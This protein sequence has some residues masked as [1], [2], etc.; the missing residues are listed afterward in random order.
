MTSS[1]DLQGERSRQSHAGRNLAKQTAA[2]R[3]RRR[4][5]RQRPPPARRRWRRS[6][7]CPR[8][9][10]SFGGDRHADHTRSGRRRPSRV[11]VAGVSDGLPD[12][13]RAIPDVLKHWRS[14]D[15]AV[16]QPR[17]RRRCRRHDRGARPASSRGVKAAPRWRAREGS[18][19]P[20]RSPPARAGQSNSRAS[21]I[22][23]G[24]A[25]AASMS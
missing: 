8:C 24:A 25:R 21:E 7:A 6:G 3:S 11:T 5:R 12:I 23:G 1:R 4:C 2:A 17:Q 15:E 14:A 10:L 18:D 20:R 22:E 9:G 16:E 13:G 19:R